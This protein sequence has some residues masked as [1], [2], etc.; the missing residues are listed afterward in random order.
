MVFRYESDLVN[1]VLMSPDFWMKFK[2]GIYSSKYKVEVSGLFGIP[3]LVVIQNVSNVYFRSI[4]FEMKLTNW[5]RALI[6]AFRYRA[7]A[8]RS[9]V[10]IDNSNVESAKKNISRFIKS[11]IGLI[12]IDI[13]GKVLIHYFPEKKTPYSTPLKNKFEE[14]YTEFE[15]IE[16]IKF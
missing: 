11:N 5:R 6:Q 16:M 10:V 1:T 8:E 15:P 4:A 3:D 2:S 9:I 13:N 14:L 12:S 7:F